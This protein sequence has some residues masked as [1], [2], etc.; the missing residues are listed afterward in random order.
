MM[1]NGSMPKESENFSTAHCMTLYDWNREVDEYWIELFEKV[2]LAVDS[3]PV[4][5]IANLDGKNVSGSYLRSKNRIRKFL[6]KAPEWGEFD[7]RIRS[8]NT[9]PGDEAFPSEYELSLSGSKLRRKKLCFAARH[10]RISSPSIMMEIIGQTIIDYTGPCYGGVF[11]FPAHFG[12]SFYLSSIAVSPRGVAWDANQDYA[13]RITRWRDRTAHGALSPS[14]GYFREIYEINLLTDGHL[15][16][17][18]QGRP[19]REFAASV[20]MIYPLPYCEGMYRWDIPK[21]ALKRVQNLMEGSGL[22]LSA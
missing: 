2:F 17:P 12:P 10:G 3:E 5:G 1:I 18:F 7:V 9:N 16:N 11:E 4:A 15:R 22:V 19:F 13:D 8:A 21:K 20:S 6:E 14:A